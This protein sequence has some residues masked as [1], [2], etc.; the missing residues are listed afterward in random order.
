MNWTTIGIICLALAV[1]LGPVLFLQPSKRQR[2]LAALRM[3]AA[4]LGMDV[5]MA[6]IKDETYAAYG[7]PWPLTDKSKQKINSWRAEKM[8]YA[9]GLH[10]AGYW[11]AS[12]EQALPSEL[13]AVLGDML[14]QLPE[15]VEAVEVTGRGARCYWSERGGEEALRALSAWLDNFIIAAV[16]FIR[17]QPAV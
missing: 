6:K 4:K 7:K 8:P 10:I 14:D 12:G 9:H 1:V 3:Q 16:P 5:K 13:V 11:H 15:G 17:R 2:R